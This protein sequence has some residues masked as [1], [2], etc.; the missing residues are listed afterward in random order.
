MERTVAQCYPLLMSDPKSLKVANL[1]YGFGKR[2]V[3]KNVS[4]T[5]VP[6]RVTLLLG[7][8][9]AGKTTLF[10]LIAGLL[11]PQAG[12][13]QLPDTGKAGLSIVFQQPAL[14]LDLTVAQNLS[15]HAGLFGL[16]A[17]ESGQRLA[18]LLARLELGTRMNDKLR[19]LNG[20]HRRRVEIIRALMTN[21]SLLL[22]DEPTAGLDPP[23]RAA[24]VTYLHDMARE[25]NIAVLWA[26][27]LTDESQADDDVIVLRD[28][29]LIASGSQSDIFTVTRATSLDQAFHTLTSSEAA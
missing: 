26:T 10:S 2:V 4:F 24:L 19:N 18:P 8:N 14:D 5:V 9:G 25:R 1:A 21:P 17:Q 6:G 7:P 23:T 12:T 16:D 22:L 15:Y 13:I 28:G 20:G 27:H 29:Q 3:L 11:A